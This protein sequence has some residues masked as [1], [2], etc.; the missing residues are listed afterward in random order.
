MSRNIIVAVIQFSPVADRAKNYQ[1]AT[2]LVRV[3]HAKGATIILI[4]ELFSN[5]Y[6]CKE[7]RSD[8]FSLAETATA[9]QTLKIF[10]ALAR[11]LRVVLPIS[12][13]ELSQN[14]YYNSV[15]VLD[16]DGKNLGIYRKSHIPDGDG[17]EEKFYFAPGDTGFSVWQTAY[18]TIGVGICWDQWFPEAARIMALKGAELLLYPTAIG[19]E[20]ANPD[21]DSSN[22]WQNVM[23]GHAAAN[24]MPVLAANRFGKEI[25]TN[26]TTIEFYGRS[27]ISD[28]QGNKIIEA[29]RTEEAVLTANFAL[30][31]I[32]AARHAWGVFRDR[33][34]DLYQPLLTLDGKTH[35]TI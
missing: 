4:P 2:E 10:S 17:Y 7:M 20:P 15:A 22:H 14:V 30:D 32:Q 5:I 21:F 13:Y 12:F 33:R 19:S 28:Q 31:D 23:L 25:A 18:A 35:K 8:Y 9:S 16:A 1:K 26:G 27:F 11:E 6:F 29:G 24:I 3:A 34:P